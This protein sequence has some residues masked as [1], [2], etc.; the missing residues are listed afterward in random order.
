MSEYDEVFRVVLVAPEGTV[1]P[2][3]R[4]YDTLGA[5]RNRRS[6]LQNR[7][8]RATQEYGKSPRTYRVQ[9]ATGPWEFVN[10]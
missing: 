9:V 3:S 2:V 8:D 1:K 10:P 5:A 6:Y 4:P 7:A